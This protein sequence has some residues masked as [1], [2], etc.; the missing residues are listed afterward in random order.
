MA[1]S[2]MAKVMIVSHRTEASELLEA[3]Q[4]EGI[5]QILNAQEAMVSRDW[6]ELAGGAERPKDIEELLARLTKTIAFLKDYTESA[7]GLAGL[8]SPRAVID[9]RLYNQTV[10]D[11]QFPGILEQCEQNQAAIEKLNAGIESL[12]DTLGRLVPWESLETPVEEL[13]RLGQTTALAGL[14]PGH[15]FE[16]VQGRIADFGAAIQQI[17]TANNKCACIIVCLNVDLNEVQKL[18]RSADF[19]QVNFEPMKGTAAELIKHYRQQLEE[20]RKQLQGQ[21]EKAALISKNLLKLQI[22]YDHYENLLSREQTRGAAPA[23]EATVILEGWVKKAELPRLEKTVSRFSASSLSKIEPAEGEEIPVEIENRNL[24]RPFEVITRLYGMPQHFNIDPTVFLAPFFAVFFGLCLADA[25]Y[26]LVMVIVTA[27]LIKK[28][29]GDRKLV[30]MLGICGAA[31]IIV[32]V[33]TG[34]WFGD[35]IQ[36][37]LPSLEPL[38]KKVMLFDPLAD[39]KYFLGLALALGYF[40]LMTGLVIAFIHNLKQ[41]DYITAICNQLTW[42]V[43]L[44]SVVIF[45]AGKTGFIPAQLGGIFGKIALVPAAMIFL[46]SHREGSWAGRLGMGFF[47]LFSSIFYLGDVLSYLRLM[48]LGMVGAGMAMAVNVI[49]KLVMKWPYGTGIVAMIVIMA[50]FHLFNLALSIL[51]AF[52]HTLRL[53]YV[54]FF[55][56]FLIGGGRAFEPLSKKYKHICISKK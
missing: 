12:C 24:V 44:N 33:L 37:F 47:N 10:S 42:L 54:E 2:Q 48:A 5:C 4:Q 23:T 7:K 55:P 36:Q 15:L 3:L 14:I 17:S 9:E 34:G 25:G 27:L 1:I 29:Q 45:G 20:T 50:S 8:L 13:G 56:K 26:G 19:E 6:P 18:L 53:Q 39:A 49:A 30:A 41:K 38:R 21:Y 35:A 40:Q 46:F 32:G 52:V 11:R 43:M 16:Q 28:M 22:L 31:T 51:S